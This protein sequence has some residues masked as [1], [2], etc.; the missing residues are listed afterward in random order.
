MARLIT[1]NVLLLLSLALPFLFHT[2]SAG[3]RP[4]RG[5]PDDISHGPVVYPKPAAN[6]AGADAA[7]GPKPPF[8]EEDGG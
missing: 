2:V 3:G 8:S 7:S 4:Y 5:P 6:A 1:L